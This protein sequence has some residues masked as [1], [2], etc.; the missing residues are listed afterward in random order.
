MS[1]RW[2]IPAIEPSAGIAPAISS[3]PVRCPAVWAWTANITLSWSRRGSNPLP[4]ACHAGA[5][6]VELRPRS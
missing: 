4:P 2:T 3:L 6:P 1:F 5:L